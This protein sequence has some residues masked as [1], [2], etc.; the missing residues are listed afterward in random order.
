MDKHGVLTDEQVEKLKVYIDKINEVEGNDINFDDDTLRV[1]SGTYKI[2]EKMGGG[3]P[4]KAA[5]WRLG[6]S[7]SSH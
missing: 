7:R 2:I 1:L 3:D 6:L 5:E 4:I